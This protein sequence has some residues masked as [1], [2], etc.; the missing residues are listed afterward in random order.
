MRARVG[1]TSGLNATGRPP[2]SVKWNN[3]FTISSPLLRVKSSVGS[4]IG[5]SYSEYP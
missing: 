3:C 2:P 1:V 4:R 5:P